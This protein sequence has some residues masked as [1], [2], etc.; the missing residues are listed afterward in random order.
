MV[1]A[2]ALL[3]SVAACGDD[4]D[5]PK[6]DPKEDA[7]GGSDAGGSDAG[8]G[9]ASAAT[10]AGP[11]VSDASVT[12]LVEEVKDKLISCNVLEASSPVQLFPIGSTSDKCAATCFANADCSNLEAAAC[13]GAPKGALAS[14]LSSCEFQCK[15][16]SGGTG[17]DAPVECDGYL[18]CDDKSDEA[19]CTAYYFTCADGKQNVNL[20]YK[21]DGGDV[22]DCD[23]GSDEKGCPAEFKCTTGNESVPAQWRCDLQPDCTD[24]SD[25]VGCGLQCN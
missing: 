15:D 10:D 2:A 22:P 17:N 18:D 4:S 23:D 20:T 8:A 1:L 13:D 5:D 12:D 14:C 7:G 19:K 25:E 21:C 6:T 3:L 11:V 9:D 16:G 24:E